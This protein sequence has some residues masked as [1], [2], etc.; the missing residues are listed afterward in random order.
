MVG[1]IQLMFDLFLFT[2]LIPQKIKRLL[3]L[4]SLRYQL[5]VSP[6][7]QCFTV[8]TGAH[9]VLN[10]PDSCCVVVVVVCVASL[11]KRNKNEPLT[12]QHV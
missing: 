1:L 9:G 12:A 5:F 3:H 6:V 2:V 8:L 7:L 11:T 10:S 4:L